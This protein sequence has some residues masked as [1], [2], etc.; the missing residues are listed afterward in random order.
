MNVEQLFVEARGVDTSKEQ[1]AEEAVR[2]PRG[3]IRSR[4]AGGGADSQTIHDLNLADRHLVNIV[5]P[6]HQQDNM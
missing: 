1:R 6:L 2:T 4:P 3:L 5:P